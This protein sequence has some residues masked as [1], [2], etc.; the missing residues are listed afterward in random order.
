[1]NRMRPSTSSTNANNSDAH[2]RLQAQ[3]NAD[4]DWE[5]F[6][7]H[8]DNGLSRPCN[9]EQA[10]KL[11]SEIK[12]LDDI[13][14][15]VQLICQSPL[16][17]IDKFACT[18]LIKKFQYSFD[19]CRKIFDAL[20]ITRQADTF[21]FNYFIDA[22]GNNNQF[23]AAQMAF[24]KAKMLGVAN[25][26]TFA[27]FI[28]LAG[29]N[30]QFKAASRAFSKAKKEG[31]TDVIIFNNFIKAAG[32]NNQYQL[33]KEAFEKAKQLGIANVIT[34]NRFINAAG[35][36]RRFRDATEAF[37]EA[38]A[39]SKLA[40]A[41]TF[42]SFIAACLVNNK[43][44]MAI[45]TFKEVRAD[46]ALFAKPMQV[47]ENTFDLQDLT[48]ASTYI[49]LYCIINMADQQSAKLQFIIG[50]KDHPQSSVYFAEKAVEDFCNNYHIPYQ[51][52]A[53]IFIC[54][55]NRAE[56]TEPLDFIKC[57]VSMVIEN[58]NCIDYAVM[59]DV[60]SATSAASYNALSS[61]SQAKPF[62][63][64][65]DKSLLFNQHRSG[66]PESFDGAL[67]SPPLTPLPIDATEPPKG[68]WEVSMQFK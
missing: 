14:E 53:G 12:L 22:A 38:T 34:L 52:N 5:K 20:V 68:V 46:Q 7:I 24:D 36:N 3:T 45:T 1:M 66:S 60:P 43:V 33:A 23:P 27:K 25:V 4:T 64:A 35:K 26:I 11:L 59:H 56:L 48:Y 62:S 18:Y 32:K 39:S 58:G 50:Q 29:N 19:L 40:D 65:G 54:D 63:N 55:F 41:M 49:A 15:I 28:E 61:T 47:D 31:L 57:N 42:H 51:N 67:S 16:C 13:N 10:E 44:D 37:N 21:T 30:K 2:T 6:F 9:S 8:L 17:A